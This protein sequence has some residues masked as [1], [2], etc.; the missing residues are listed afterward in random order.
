MDV[1]FVD[2]HVFRITSESPRFARVRAALSALLRAAD[3]RC[4]RRFAA[5]RSAT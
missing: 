3:S 2:E 4:A 1:G 5:M